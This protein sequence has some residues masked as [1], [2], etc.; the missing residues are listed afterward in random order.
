MTLTRTMIA[1]TLGLLLT[2]SLGS[3]AKS[4]QP[5]ATDLTPVFH[6]ALPGIENLRAF[7]IGGIV[8]LRG[9]AHDYAT[10]E[11]AGVFAQTLGY[12]R[13]ANLVQIV[14][15]PDDQAIE[16]I[17]ERELALHRSLDGCTFHVDSD[18]GV[19]TVA[20]NVHEDTQKDLAVAVLRNIDGV[21]Q[22]RADLVRR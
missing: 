15:A 19:V 8:V 13:I 17:A 3:A 11:Q 10:A 9:R 7:E 20:G 22:V 4:E 21:K 5:Q 12:T 2:A 18:H 14:A 16:R 1:L 6:S